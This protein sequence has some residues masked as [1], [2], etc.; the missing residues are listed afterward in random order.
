MNE[1]RDVWVCLVCGF[2]GCGL[3]VTG[4]IERHFNEH[5][6]AYAMNTD[7]RHV[8]DFAGGG[9]VHRLAVHECNSPRQRE[10]AVQEMTDENQDDD[11]VKLNASSSVTSTS[12]QQQQPIFP[13]RKIFEVRTLLFTHLHPHNPLALRSSL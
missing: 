10:E 5:Q 7:T 12:Q 3:R 4:H 9:F 11:D 1:D 6:H 2:V 13:N 8:W